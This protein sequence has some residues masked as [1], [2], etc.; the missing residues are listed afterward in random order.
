MTYG[1]IRFTEQS[2]WGHHHLLQKA[3]YSFINMHL[4][5]SSGTFGGHLHGCDNEA[6]SHRQ[7]EQRPE[8][9]SQ[10]LTEGR[11]RGQVRNLLSEPI[12]FEQK[13]RE[14]K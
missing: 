11:G 7:T 9:V 3:L 14:V 10:A 13:A 5:C 2:V 4:L 8:K 6:E 12:A 1:P